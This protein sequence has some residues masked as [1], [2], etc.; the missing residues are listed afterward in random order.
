[1]D[2][3]MSLLRKEYNT[4]DDKDYKL[5]CYWCAKFSNKAISLITGM[6]ASTINIK[7]G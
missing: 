5:A 6:K 7:E 1:M 2:N 4:F 3:V